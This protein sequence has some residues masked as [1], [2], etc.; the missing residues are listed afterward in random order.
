[1]KNI[2]KK[3]LRENLMNEKS[4]SD[5]SIDEFNIN[6]IISDWLNSS[7]DG[8]ALLFAYEMQNDYN[9]SPE[10]KEEIMRAN[11]EDVIETERFKNWI[12]YEVEYKIEDFISEIQNYFKGDTITIWREMTVDDKWLELLPTTGKR[13]GKYWSYEEDAA[14][15][16]WGGSGIK[17]R[18]QTSVDEKFID[19]TQTIIANI[20]PQVGES[21]KEITLF[22]NTPLKLEKL[23]VNKQEMDISNFRNKIFKA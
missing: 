22:K 14:E 15:A 18:L 21:E 9:L 5:V 6:E 11:Y 1:M 19:W 20:D 23:I 13:L 12:A 10:E 8:M 7:P 3:L 2:I 16:H 4:I 17:I